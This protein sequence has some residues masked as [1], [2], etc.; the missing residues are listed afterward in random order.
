MKDKSSKQPAAK[1]ASEQHMFE[2]IQ[3]RAYEIWEASGCQP[4]NEVANWIEAERE[5]R[6]LDAKQPS[7]G[8]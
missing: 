2:R 6:M 8:A 1:A 7:R 5:V 3:Q 4:G